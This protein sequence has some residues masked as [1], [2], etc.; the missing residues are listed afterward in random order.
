MADLIIFMDTRYHIEDTTDRYHTISHELRTKQAKVF[1]NMIKEQ[2][3]SKD[4]L[5]VKDRKH[6][7]IPLVSQVYYK[8]ADVHSLEKFKIKS[9]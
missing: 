4:L 1:Q 6:E 5:V 3:K 9:E 8:L 2:L 7:V